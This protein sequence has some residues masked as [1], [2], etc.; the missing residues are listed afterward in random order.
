[1]DSDTVAVQGDAGANVA[2]NDRT[3]TEKTTTT[4]ADSSSGNVAMETTPSIPTPGMTSEEQEDDITKKPETIDAGNDSAADGK[5]E[6]AVEGEGGNAQ[7][8][9]AIESDSKQESEG[10]SNVGAVKPD[11]N[12]HAEQKAENPPV[13]STQAERNAQ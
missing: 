6:N 5:Q 10:N 7:A 11:E 9:V 1:M 13:P 12:I 2:S 4:G 3:E 8:D